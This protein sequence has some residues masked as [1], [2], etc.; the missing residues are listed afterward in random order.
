M[1]KKKEL[2]MA[3]IDLEKAFDRVPR[4]VIWWALRESGVG[5]RMIAVIKS[6]YIGATTSVKIEGSESEKFPV[7]VGVH[8]GSVLSPFLFIIVLEALSKKFRKGLPYEL[9]YAD[10]LVLIAETEK[11]LME[12]I[13]AWRKGLEAGGLRVNFGKTKI[14]RCGIDSGQVK[15]SGKYPCG[16]CRKGVGRN[17][18]MCSKCRKWIHKKCSKINGRLRQDPEYKCPVCSGKQCEESDARKT[19]AKK[20][21]RIRCK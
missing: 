7:K 5:E 21:Q 11:L 15:S 19:N 6:M 12:K 4:E 13:D 8:Q 17:S 3:F 20:L 18:I 2:W 14:M 9:L 1:E 16:V 10:D